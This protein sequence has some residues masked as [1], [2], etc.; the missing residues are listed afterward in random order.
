LIWLYLVT[1]E[2][3]RTF[4][5]RHLRV[6]VDFIL[7]K[8]VRQSLV[9]TFTSLAG[10][11]VQQDSAAHVSLSSIFN[12]QRTDFADAM[13]WAVSLLA[14]APVEC[15]SRGSLWISQGR[16]LLSPAARRPRCEAYIV[17]RLSGCQQRIRSFLNFLRRPFPARRPTSA[18]R[19]VNSLAPLWPRHNG[20]L[21][22]PQWRL[23]VEPS[24]KGARQ[25]RSMEEEWRGQTRRTALAFVDFAPRG[26][27][28][29]RQ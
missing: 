25:A 12:C 18:C 24:S 28:L 4:T 1:L 9:R 19:K 21:L 8:R 11:G 6:L 7:S 13:S 10:H 27:Q 17:V 16:T 14:R 3:T 5:P 15:R 20:A 23:K 2:L 22:R 29:S 26:R